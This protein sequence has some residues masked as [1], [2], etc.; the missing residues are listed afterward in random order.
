MRASQ[1]EWTPATFQTVVEKVCELERDTLLQVLES[2]PTAEHL[3]TLLQF[4]PK[5]ASTR[6][7]LH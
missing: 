4:V 3:T 7:N 6:E 1:V 5:P 2:L